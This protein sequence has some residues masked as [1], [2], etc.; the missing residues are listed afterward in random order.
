MI[1]SF[2]I[3]MASGI[4]MYMLL[5]PPTSLDAQEDFA[6]VSKPKPIQTYTPQSVIYMT[7]PK[8]NEAVFLRHHIM[9]NTAKSMANT[10]D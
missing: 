8:Q 1:I 2:I 9:M 6:Q 3:V 4:L 7:I 10:N 5:K